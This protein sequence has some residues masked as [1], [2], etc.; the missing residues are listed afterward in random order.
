MVAFVVVM[1]GFFLTQIRTT[2]ITDVPFTKLI[3]YLFLTLYSG[4]G[5]LLWV[6]RPF[7][8]RA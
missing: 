3:W 2:Q 5:F 8:A 1:G 6:L 4:V 7:H